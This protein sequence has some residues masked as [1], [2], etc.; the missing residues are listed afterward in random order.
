LW[1]L[2]GLRTSGKAIALTRIANKSP[3]KVKP[4]C[5]RKRAFSPADIE[6]TPVMVEAGCRELMIFNH[7]YESDDDAVTRIYRAMEYVN[8]CSKDAK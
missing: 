2:S 6:V 7:D 1:E 4:A 8:Y 3:R 5:R